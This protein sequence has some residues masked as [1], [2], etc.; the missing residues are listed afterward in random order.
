MVIQALNYLHRKGFRN[1]LARTCQVAYF[2]KGFGYVQ[3][4]YHP[5][6]RAYAYR[7]KGITFL[8]LGPGWAYNFEY[9]K[10]LLVQTY[11]HYYIPKPGDCVVDIGS[12]LGE[13]TVIYAMLVGSKGSVHALEANPST[14]AGLAYMCKQN[15]FSWTTP[16]HVAIYNSDGEV[17]IEDDEE[18]YLTNTINVERSREPGIP[19]KAKTLDTLVRENNITRIDFLKSNIEGAEQYLIQGMDESIKIIRNFCISCHDFRHNYHSHGEFYMTKSKVKAFLEKHGF[20]I[21]IR[22]TGNRVVDD[23]IYARNTKIA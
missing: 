3:S 9:L 6:F 14:F 23:Y 17:T 1:L 8:S 12:G 4:T 15:K 22:N 21:A 20:E 5:D 11:C 19:V 10:D 16:H 7:V 13:E 2:L 18:N